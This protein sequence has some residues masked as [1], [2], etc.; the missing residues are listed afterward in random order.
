MKDF[1]EFTCE[2]I[3]KPDV[4]DR[5]ESFRKKT[6]PRGTVPVDV[7]LIAERLGIEIIPKRD[8]MDVEA[9]LTI[10]G[11]AILVNAWKYD[12]PAYGKRVRFS[13][14]HE[15]GHAVFHLDALKKL[16]IESIEDYLAFTRAISD[17]D[18]R[19]FE[20]Q[21]NEFAGR[22][23]VPIENLRSELDKAVAIIMQNNLSHLVRENPDQV[24]AR[25]SS[26]IADAFD[27]SAEVIETRAM[28]EEVWPPPV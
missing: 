7:E 25:I 4:W 1:R 27:V 10:D 14:A 11:S 20:W 21:A 19:A 2:F 6:W 5:V 28:R 18:Y 22:L 9:F 13:I 15:L 12:K 16:K 26:R 3:R 24:L 8:L 23:L 17:E